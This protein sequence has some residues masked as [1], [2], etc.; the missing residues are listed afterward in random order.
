M[1]AKAVGTD[2][3]VIDSAE[4]TAQDVAR[5]LVDDG[6]LRPTPNVGSLRCFVT[7][8]PTRFRRLAPRFLGSTLNQEPTLVQLA[9]ATPA[10]GGQT[11]RVAV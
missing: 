10:T 11:M 6:L 1:I 9:D 4:Q 5:R 3:P 7:D 8:A 2:C